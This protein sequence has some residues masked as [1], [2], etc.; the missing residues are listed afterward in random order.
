MEHEFDV[1]TQASSLYP[2]ENAPIQEDP[3][4]EIRRS[5]RVKNSLKDLKQFTKLIKWK[6]LKNQ[7]P[8]KFE[9][10]GSMDKGYRFWVQFADNE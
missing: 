4:S 1:E 8:F 9:W 7:N 10:S 2:I 5:S 3:V 6:K